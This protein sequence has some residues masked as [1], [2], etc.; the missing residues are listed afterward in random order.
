MNDVYFFDTYAIIEI[1]KGNKN[2]SGLLNKKFIITIFNLVEL[3]YKLLR[4]FNEKL[5]DSI[6]KKYSSH[7]TPISLEII[8]DSNKFKLKNK[9]KN[10]SA[11]DATGYVT[12]LKNNIKFV[13]GDEQFKNFDNVKFIK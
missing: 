10:L 7:V 6:L 13:T 3:H 11:P 2:Y 8:K 9:H 1:M 4:D 12:A 5:A